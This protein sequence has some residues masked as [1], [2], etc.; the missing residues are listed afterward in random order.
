M[1][2]A[3]EALS[4]CIGAQRQLAGSQAPFVHKAP[5]DFSVIRHR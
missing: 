4:F 2:M 3:S 1:E 5:S